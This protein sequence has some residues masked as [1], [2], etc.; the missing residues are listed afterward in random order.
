MN[1]KRGSSPTVR[2]GVNLASKA[3]SL[4]VGLPPPVPLTHR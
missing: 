1:A 3:P 4:A 2:E